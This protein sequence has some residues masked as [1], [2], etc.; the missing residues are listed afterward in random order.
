VA[1]RS[2]LEQQIAAVWRE[3]LRLDEVGVRDNF[4]DLGGHSLLLVRVHAKLRKLLDREFRV[5]E[6][7][8]FP[9]IESLARYLG[10]EI[11][12]RALAEEARARVSRRG[13]D[14]GQGPIAIVGMAG[15]FPGADSVETFWENLRSGVESITFSSEEELIEAGVDPALVRDP[16]YVPSRGVMDGAEDFDAPLFGYPPRE[17]ELIDPQQRVFLECAWE[18]LERAGYDPQRFPGLVGVYAGSSPNSYLANIQSRPDLL[19]SVG[20]LAVTLGSSPDFLPTRV[21]YKLN[22]RGPSVNVQTA[23]STSL[24]AVHAACRA[25]LDHDCDLALAGGV[26]VKVPRK[27]GHVFM[28]EGIGSPDGHCRAFDADAQGTVGGDGVARSGA[29]RSTTTARSRSATRRRAW[30]DRPRRSPWR[31]LPRG[32]SPTRSATSRRTG[33]APPSAI[34]SRWP[35]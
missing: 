19:A 16:R 26:S 28:E 12:E 7:F 20:G 8:Q 23:C 6:L 33:P 15:R 31:R 17:A 10:G 35:H 11:E 25:L 2:E 18:A 29:R 24:V 30:R 34:P 1:P 5:V 27:V 32:W 14:A 3:V 9:T 4:F 21:S 22:L 13:L